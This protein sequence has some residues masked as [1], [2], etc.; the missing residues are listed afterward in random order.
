MKNHPRSFFNRQNNLDWTWTYSQGQ[1]E[2]SSL[3]R[4]LVQTRCRRL[5]VSNGIKKK[6]N[7]NS[8]RSPKHQITLHFIYSI[9]KKKDPPWLP[10]LSPK[11]RYMF[12]SS[13]ETRPRQQ[14][15]VMRSG[16]I[17]PIQE[18]TQESLQRLIS[19]SS[20]RQDYCPLRSPKTRP[21]PS[22]VLSWQ[23]AA[24]CLPFL[25]SLGIKEQPLWAV[26]D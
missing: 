9:K 20:A 21:I 5:L 13:R 18:Q 10:F 23:F 3:R 16:L 22:S 17:A 8:G 7:F 4:I 11:H 24:L 15:G 14:R 6:R 12:S 2:F 1:L 26:S 19:G 25:W